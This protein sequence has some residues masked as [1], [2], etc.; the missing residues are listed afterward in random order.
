[1]VHY[2]D[3]FGGPGSKTQHNRT[4][5]EDELGRGQHHWR[6]RGFAAHARPLQEA[7]GQGRLPFGLALKPRV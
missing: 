7:W 4:V 2:L 6:L 5:R 3:C 1:M